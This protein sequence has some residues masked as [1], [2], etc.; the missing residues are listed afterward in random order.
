MLIDT[1]AAIWEKQKPSDLALAK[2]G[3]KFYKRQ[4]SINARKN[5]K[6]NNRN[7]VPIIANMHLRNNILWSDIVWSL[8]TQGIWLRLMMHKSLEWT[9]GIRESSIRSWLATFLNAV[10]TSLILTYYLNVTKIQ[11]IGKTT[12]FY[13]I[14]YFLY[15]FQSQTFICF[16]YKK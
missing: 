7:T 4:I 8:R 1:K 14:A 9:L 5:E 10:P 2:I 11:F 3:S 16:L 15:S 12:F 13:K 6:N